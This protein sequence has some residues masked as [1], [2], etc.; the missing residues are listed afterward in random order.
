VPATAPTEDRV[1]RGPRRTVRQFDFGD[2]PESASTPPAGPSIPASRRKFPTVRTVRTVDAASNER[3]VSR[4]SKSAA[5]R[6]RRSTVNSGWYW[7]V[8]R[9]ASRCRVARAG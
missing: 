5:I 4:Q 7:T 8:Q 6:S 1:D 3:S 2:S 9:G